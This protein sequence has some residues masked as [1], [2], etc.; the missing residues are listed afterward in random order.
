MDDLIRTE[1]IVLD[2]KSYGEKSVIL[3]VFSRDRGIINIFINDITKTKYTVEA[4]V[5]SI[6]DYL[7]KKSANFYY[8]REVDLVHSNMAL[9]SSYKKQ[10]YSLIM[11]DLIKA[12]FYDDV[13]E[14]KVYDLIKKSAIFIGRSDKSIHILNA[15]IIKLV[16]YL[17]YMPN[18]DS[19]NKRYFSYESGFTDIQSDESV[20][21]DEIHAKYLIFL[22]KN[23]FEDILIPEYR[24]ID[25]K[26][27]L[28][29]LIKYTMNNFGLD[30]LGSLNYIEYL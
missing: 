18:L 24:N 15:F 28:E 8:I 25:G 14:S 2:Y 10:V 20:I 22:A 21:I 12:I 17:G 27:I 26:K 23:I 7:L 16:S 29:V 5:L 1:A 13:A 9:R 11:A 6:S 30:Y 4:N 3:N 19:K